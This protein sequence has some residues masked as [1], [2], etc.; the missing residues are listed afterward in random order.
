MN[1]IELQNVGLVF[2]TKTQRIEIFRDLNLAFQKQD[3]VA[4]VGPSGMGKSTLLN[5]ISGFVKPT[6]GEIFIDGKSL[7]AMKD[8]EICAYRNQRIGYIFQAYNLI[9]QFNVRDNV[10]VPLLLNGQPKDAAEQQVTALL[11]QVKMTDRAYEYPNTLSGGE[12]QRVAF[13]RAIANSPDII[14]ADE[15][16]GNLDSTN[17]AKLMDMLEDLW[18]AGKTIL[19]VT[20][21]EKLKNRANTVINIENIAYK[22]QW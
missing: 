5:L 14:L 9:P 3:F 10:A 7:T 16:T 11:E 18:K 22:E 17:A 12:Q 8:K 1:F 2:K 20:H 21:D 19:C 4:I 15:P 6:A 13:A